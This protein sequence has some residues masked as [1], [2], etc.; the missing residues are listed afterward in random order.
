MSQNSAKANSA[1]PMNSLTRREREDPA[2][3]DLHHDWQHQRPQSRTLSEEPLQVHANLLL[4]EPG[5][6][7]FFDARSIERRREQRRNLPKQRFG[8]GVE[9]ETPCN[10]VRGL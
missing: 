1:T 4:D 6:G 5:I 9:D 10:Y 8:P 3:S 7:S 2:T